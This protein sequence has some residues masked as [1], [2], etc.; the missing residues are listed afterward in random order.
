M[1]IGRQGGEGDD[2]W[3]KSLATGPQ[4]DITFN[5][6]ANHDTIAFEQGT[7]PMVTTGSNIPPVAIAVTRNEGGGAL[8][9]QNQNTMSLVQQGFQLSIPTTAT[10]TQQG[11]LGTTVSAGAASN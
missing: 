7:T 1:P 2:S 5:D 11:G 4:F 3:Q 9:G 8:M 6:F 10:V